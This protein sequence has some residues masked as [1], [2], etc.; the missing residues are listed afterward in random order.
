MTA[1]I[2]CPPTA[3]RT[4]WCVN[5]ECNGEFPQAEFSSAEDVKNKM[6]SPQGLPCRAYGGPAPEAVAVQ[7]EHL[8]KFVEERQG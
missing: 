4:E 2:D 5:S 6:G 1:V 3:G 7:L 8:K